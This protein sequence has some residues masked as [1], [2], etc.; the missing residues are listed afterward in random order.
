[1]LVKVRENIGYIKRVIA[2]NTLHVATDETAI[3]LIRYD[4]CIILKDNHS[5]SVTFH[6]I[7]SSEIEWIGGE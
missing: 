1:M 7:L 3:S 5:Y 6:N 2:R 4:V